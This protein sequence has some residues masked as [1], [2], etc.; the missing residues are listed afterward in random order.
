[1]LP[2]RDGDCDVVHEVDTLAKRVP[3]RES[4]FTGGDRLRVVQRERRACEERVGSRDVCG[5]DAEACERGGVA[6]VGGVDSVLRADPEAPRAHAGNHADDGD[7]RQGWGERDVV[8][9]GP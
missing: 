1:M 3:R 5:K 2:V 8:Y 4:V 9:A 7:G 6:A